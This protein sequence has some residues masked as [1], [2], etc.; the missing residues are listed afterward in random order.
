MP[1]SNPI[2]GLIKYN[3]DTEQNEIKTIVFAHI[4]IIIMKI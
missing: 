1:F 4:I 3:F 2:K